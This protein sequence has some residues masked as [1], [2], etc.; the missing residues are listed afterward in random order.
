MDG[1]PLTGQVTQPSKTQLQL[2]IKSVT[3]VV[4]YQCIANNSLGINAMVTIIDVASCVPDSPSITSLSC[5]NN[6]MSIAWDSAETDNNL[7]TAF[8]VQVNKVTYEVSPSTNSLQI[9]GCEDSIVLVTAENKCGKSIPAIAIMST[10][11][12]YDASS[13]KF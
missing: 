4:H 1:L 5:S 10:T 12:I 9:H 6:T 13:C 2:Y 7:P 8:A 3:E 11:T